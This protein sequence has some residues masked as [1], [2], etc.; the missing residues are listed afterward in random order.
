MEEHGSP[1]GENLSGR[2]RLADSADKNTAGTGLNT[3]VYAAGS[4][5]ESAAQNLVKDTK[6]ASE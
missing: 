5:I 3:A 2:G 1:G 4:G 6:K